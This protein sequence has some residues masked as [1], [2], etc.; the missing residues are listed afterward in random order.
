[1]L[2]NPFNEKTYIVVDDF[3]DMR[4]T[5]RSMLRSFGVANVDQ[6]RDGDEAIAQMAKTRYD[7]L[8]VDY[9][10]GRGK[11]GQQVLEEARHRDLIGVDSIFIMIT[12]ESA[13]DMVMGVVEYEPDS[14]LSKPFTKDLLRTRLAKLIERKT[15]LSMVNK[16]LRGKDFGRAINLCDELIARRPKHLSELLKL[17]A[18]TCLT[19]G[20]FDEATA[21]YE[22]ILAAREIAWARLGIGRVLFARKSY[23]EAEAVFQH[24]VDHHQNLVAAYDWLAK[25]QMVMHLTDAAELT[26]TKAVSLSPRAIRRQRT[27]GELALANGNA[28]VAEKAF[29]SAVCLAKHS[30]FNDPSLFCGLAKS[31]IANRKPDA[32]LRV[33]EDLGR[34]FSDDARTAFYR[35]TATAAILWH[36]GDAEAAAVQADKAEAAMRGVDRAFDSSQALEMAA[37]FSLL[38]SQEKADD[39]LQTVVANNH[40]DDALLAEVARAYR[41]IG[42]GEAPETTITRIRQAVRDTNNRGVKLIREGNLDAAIELLEQAAAEVTGNRTVNLNAAKALCL[43]MEKNGS[44]PEQLRRVRHYVDRVRHVAP[45]DWRLAHIQS[46]LQQL[47]LNS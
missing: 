15:D 29:D 13:R 23:P 24:L 46:R 2:T 36:R 8:L 18:E 21:I 44:S 17:K 5:V 22:K 41:E 38:G 6:A 4:S 42:T 20:R 40:D 30:V 9:N 32:A 39:L 27:L 19:A 31:K 33:V 35:A 45:D 12:A 16:A 37:T 3:A 25:T 7:V 11:D 47:V 34:V 43:K 14:Y 1:M 28:P 10:L 26:L